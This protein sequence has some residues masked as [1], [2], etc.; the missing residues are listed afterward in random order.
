M[1]N[2]GSD[3]QFDM[4]SSL[5]HTRIQHK[6]QLSKTKT[7]KCVAG[8]VFSIC[9]YHPQFLPISHSRRGEIHYIFLDTSKGKQ[10]VAALVAGTLLLLAL[11]WEK[12]EKE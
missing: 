4:T 10:N 9:H 1:A 11:Q 6:T 5:S 12:R 8:I 2:V 3:M 7:L